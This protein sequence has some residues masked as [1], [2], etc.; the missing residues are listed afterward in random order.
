M[1]IGSRKRTLIQA[2]GEDAIL[3]IRRL[4]CKREICNL[5]HHELPDILVPYKRHEAETIE[6]IIEPPAE[7]EEPS[8]PCEA[9]TVYRIKM[10]FSLLRQYLEST[11]QAL[12]VLYRADAA[13]YEQLYSLKPMSAEYRRETAGWLK[14][15]V[16]MVV[17]C[18]R[19]PHTRLAYAD[20]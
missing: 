18:G 13:L 4:R 11:I 1:V 16:R 15:I 5:I 6:Q 14:R 12:K 19:W 8:Y 20:R 3:I 2:D 17:N 7:Q 9:S 10:W